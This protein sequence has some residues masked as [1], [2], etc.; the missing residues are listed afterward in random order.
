MLFLRTNDDAEIDVNEFAEVKSLLASVN[1]KELVT[2]LSTR[3]SM[4]FVL[5]FPVC[6]NQQHL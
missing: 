2:K 6:H 3:V 1:A 4:M 5:K